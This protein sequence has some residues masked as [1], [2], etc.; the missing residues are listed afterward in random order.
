MIWIVQ[1]II[2]IYFVCI[3]VR[4]IHIQSYTQESD[5]FYTTNKD[6]FIKHVSDFSPTLLYEKQC[7]LPKIDFK[8]NQVQSKSE[9]I[10]LSNYGKTDSSLFLYKDKQLS[11]KTEP[12][13]INK[14]YDSKI[15][16][17][18]QTSISVIQGEHTTSIHKNTHNYMFLETLDGYSVIYI[19][20]PKYKN[21]LDNYKEIGYQVILQPKTK[22]FIPPNWYYIQKINEKVIQKHNDIDDIFM[23]VPN[24][25]KKYIT[26][27]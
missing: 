4:M 9:L 22:L 12:I 13:D 2:C 18:S 21:E 24:L 10:S 25:I 7:Q 20:H 19:I 17:P 3:G 11:F 27:V 14:F 1:L 6:D 15:L 23:F 5:F 8:I 26:I 16:I